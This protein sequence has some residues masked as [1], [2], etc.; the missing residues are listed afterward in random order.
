SQACGPT[1]CRGSAEKPWVA[2][3]F[4]DGPWP[5]YTGQI[6]DILRD[7]GVPAAF[8]VTGVQTRKH[9]DLVSRM[10]LEGHLVGSHTDTPGHLAPGDPARRRGRGAG[11]GPP[12]RVV[13]AALRHALPLDAAAGAH[14]GPVHRSLVQLPAGLA[15]ARRR[16]AG[17]A[18][19]RHR[20]GGGR[21][22][23]AR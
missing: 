9:P 4:D 3:T 21:G 11:A 13:P 22:A 15:E 14:P 12:P 20:P 1:L 19:P 23:A 10:A 7:E 18:R 17:A 5:P 16:H 6:L 2:L 8:F